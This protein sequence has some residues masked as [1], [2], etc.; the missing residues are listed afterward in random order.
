MDVKIIRPLDKHIE[1]MVKLADEA[2]Q[3]HIDLLNGYFKP[4]TSISSGFERKIIQN[5]MND[6]ETQIVLVA[7][8]N[9]DKVL[10]FILGEKLHKPW[11]LKSHVGHV[12]NFIVSN[13][14]RMQ[15][16]GTKLM[17]AF[18]EECK[19]SGMQAIDLGVYNKNAGSYSFYIK[20]GFES[21]KQEMNMDL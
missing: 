12:S 5:H 13:N 20:Y 16:I 21:M 19:T 4:V 14:M 7:V 6:T 18:V 10:G 9:E 15:G 2:R 17:D 3:H 1:Q 11:L 8:D